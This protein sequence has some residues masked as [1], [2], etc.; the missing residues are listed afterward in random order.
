MSDN[1]KGA[2]DFLTG[3]KIFEINNSN[4]FIQK[5]YRKI[6]NDHRGDKILKRLLLK[7]LLNTNGVLKEDVQNYLNG[8]QENDGSYECNPT[9]ALRVKESSL[10]NLL[11]ELGLIEHVKR[12]DIYRITNEKL[13]LFKNSLRRKVL[14]PEALALILKQK[15]TI[16]KLAELEVLKYE[17]E[18]LSTDTKLVETVKHVAKYD[19][20]VGYDILSWESTIKKT[21]RYIEVKAVSQYCTEFYWSR[22]EIKKA[23]EFGE[24]YYLYLLPVI[25]SNKFDIDNLNIISNPS[26]N[27]FNNTKI[28]NKQVETYLFSKLTI[29]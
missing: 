5:K 16:G 12:R 15:D 28:W 25:G 6:A 29:K 23:Q 14:S 8:F 10:R 1:F 24:Q 18:R 2:I 13:E 27:I 11:M 26:V 3:I 7:E 19:V 20:N 9:T 21:H 4:I 22:N 17:K